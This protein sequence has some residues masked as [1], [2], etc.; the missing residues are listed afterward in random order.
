MAKSNLARVLAALQV[1]VSDSA[2]TPVTAGIHVW[3]EP[4]PLAQRGFWV[5]LDTE[6]VERGSDALRRS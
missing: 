2:H 4:I 6:G 5:V 3:C 1:D